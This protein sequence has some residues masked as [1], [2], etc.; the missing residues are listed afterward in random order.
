MSHEKRIAPQDASSGLKRAS[1]HVALVDR[2]RDMIVEDRLS[3][4]QRI[5]EVTLSVELGVSRTPLREALKVLAAEGL[6]ELIPNRGAVVAKA[7][8]SEIAADFQVLAVLE[9]LA[10]ELA[11]SR[12]TEEELADIR[13]LQEEMNMSFA[14]SDLPAYFRCNQAIHNAILMAAGSPALIKAHRSVSARVLASRFRANLSPARWAAA[15]QEHQV[16]LNLLELGHSHELGVVLKAHIQRK[17][18]ALLSYQERIKETQ[19]PS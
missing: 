2:V 15:L 4:G 3:P 14:R 18:E 19:T 17:L 6:V 12:I 1:M 7:T 13:S 16:I 5:N 10:G 8:P 9:G 11:A